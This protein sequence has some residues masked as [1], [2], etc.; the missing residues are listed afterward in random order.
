[1]VLVTAFLDLNSRNRSINDY[2]NYGRELLEAPVPKIVFVEQHIIDKYLSDKQF[3][4]TTLVRFERTDNYLFNLDIPNFN[5][6]TDAPDKDTADYMRVQCH[7]TEWL[8]RATEICDSPQYTWIDFGI[9]RLFK[10]Q[11]SAFHTALSHMNTRQ[12]TKIR[13]PGCWPVS[14]PFQRDVTKQIAWYFC[15]GIIGGPRE[16]IIEFASYVRNMCEMFI[17]MHG[18]LFWE[19]NIWYIIAINRPELFDMYIADHNTTMVELY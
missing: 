3:P 13:Y 18:I 16:C 12:Y 4:N 6:L 10:G 2:V 15:G 11:T 14:I 5:V 19:T 8:K 9:S 17:S 7:K 1:M